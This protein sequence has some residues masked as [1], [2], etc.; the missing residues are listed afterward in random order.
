M[1]FNLLLYFQYKIIPFNEMGG[2][3]VT[4]KRENNFSGVP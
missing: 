4:L 3:G 1:M 2:G